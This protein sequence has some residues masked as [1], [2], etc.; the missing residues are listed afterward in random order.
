MDYRLILNDAIHTV[1]V[2]PAG[3]ERFRAAIGDAVYDVRYISVSP[4]QIYFTLNG[5]GMN[6]YVSGREDEKVICIQ[7]RSW[8]I[9][10][11]DSLPSRSRK[12]GLGADPSVVTPPMP[13]VVI[14]VPVAEGEMVA[15]GQAV[16]VVSAMKMETTLAAPFDGIV[17]KVN[18]APGDKV[19]PGDILVD[20]EKS[21][22]DS[23]DES[24]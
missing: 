11:A 6:A 23:R 14:A 24:A 4:H 17:T 7:G 20:I 2:E 22:A 5:R 18:V 8:R 15:K 13:A 10:D 1:A 21:G 16:V 19:M 3:R 9:K 12:K